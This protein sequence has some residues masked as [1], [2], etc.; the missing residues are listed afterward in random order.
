MTGFTMGTVAYIAPEQVKGQQVTPSADVYSLGLVF[1]EALTGERAF[2]GTDVEMGLARLSTEP[3]TAR[4]EDPAWA[5]LIQ[6]MTAMDP[7][8]RPTVKR[9][10]DQLKNINPHPTA[11][12]PLAD[13]DRATRALPSASVATKASAPKTEPVMASVAQPTQQLQ[14]DEEPQTEQG[15]SRSPGAWWRSWPAM[16]LGAALLAVT[17]I[18]GVLATTS[19]GTQTHSPDVPGRLGDDLRKLHQVIES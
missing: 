11:V 9:V 4:V 5:R 16:A 12:L 7:S 15:S 10:R 13:A 19:T 14:T 3:S 6:H 1:L 18:I 8:A 2:A 17:G